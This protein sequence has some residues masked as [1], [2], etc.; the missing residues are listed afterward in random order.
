MA[1]RYVA[2]QPW[3]DGMTAL[4]FMCMRVCEKDGSDV[5]RVMVAPSTV[6]DR[7]TAPKEKS[8]HMPFDRTCC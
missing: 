6:T 8:D 2:F 4:L 7:L 1:Y 5:D 3:P